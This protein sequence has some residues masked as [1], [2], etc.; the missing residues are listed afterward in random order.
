MAESLNQYGDR[1][2]P[3]EDGR[4]VDISS[5]RQDEL[6]L[7]SISWINAQG[8]AGGKIKAVDLGG[9]FG[10][11][12]IRMAKAGAQVTMIDIADMASENFR[13]AV[14]SGLVQPD[15]LQLLR[16]DFATLSEAD[17]P[18]K[19][20]LLYSQRAIHYIPYLEARKLMTLCFNKMSPGGR[21]YISVAGFDTE[22]GRNYSERCKPVQERFTHGP[23]DFARHPSAAGT[24]ARRSEQSRLFRH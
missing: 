12:S 24:S 5:Q 23:A 10:A 2:T 19:Y 4:G 16:K 20:D 9:G 3:T 18:D 17:I 6:D 22:Y 14:E 1:F 21:V 7:A 15:Q 11:H 8:L 13:N